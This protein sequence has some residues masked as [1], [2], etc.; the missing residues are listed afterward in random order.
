MNDKQ[1]S[2]VNQFFSEELFRH[3]ND[4]AIFQHEDGSYEFFNKYLVRKDSNGYRVT[5]KYGFQLQVFSAL[6][7]AAAWCIFDNRNK[8]A[9]AKRLEYL[10]QMLSGSEVSIEMHKNLLRKA[11][12]T[13][14]K[15]IYAAKLSEDQNKKKRM[16]AEMQSFIKESNM[17]Q[18]QKFANKR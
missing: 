12:D 3:M 14:N 17:L 6:K 13:E 11:K 5:S 4:V 8:H 1:L 15:L 2:K 18:T 10:D 9:Q 16:L 7:F